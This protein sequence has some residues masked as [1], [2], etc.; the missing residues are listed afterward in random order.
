MISCFAGPRPNAGPQ[1]S[2]LVNIEEEAVAVDAD[3][4]RLA[5]VME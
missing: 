1:E 3:S 5:S 4:S 2:R